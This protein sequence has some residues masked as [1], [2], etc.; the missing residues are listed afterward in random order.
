M[1]TLELAN[2][3]TDDESLHRLMGNEIVIDRPAG[4][5]GQRALEP[6]VTVAL[7][8]AGAT[9]FA[10]GAKLLSELLTPLLTHLL[11]V[12]KMR[13]ERQLKP[14]SPASIHLEVRLRKELIL[15][16]SRGLE[17]GEQA[18]QW[19]LALESGEASLPIGDDTT[20][21]LELVE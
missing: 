18:R 14:V 13:L 8:G 21:R 6:L 1:T 10:A 3:A 19:L 4:P 2:F 7:I 15:S 20:I 16:D 11:E 17:N 9:L 5:S 12:R